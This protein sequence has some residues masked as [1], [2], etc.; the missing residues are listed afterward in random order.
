MSRISS[1]KYDNREDAVKGGE[2]D[3]PGSEVSIGEEWMSW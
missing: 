1:E 3:E 2:G